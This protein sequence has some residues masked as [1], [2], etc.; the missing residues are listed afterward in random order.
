MNLAKRQEGWSK[1]Q[2][3]IIIILVILLII[4]A[5]PGYL[6]GGNWTWSDLPQVENINQVKSVLKT[7][8]ELPG[9]QIIKQQ[10]VRIGGHKWSAQMMKQENSKPVML[11]LLPQ[12]YYLNKP[13]VEWMDING[14][15]RWK[16]DS[17]RQLNFT[18]TKNSRSVSVKARFF[19]AWNQQ[20][21]AVVQW[22]AFN[23]GGHFSPANWFW[24]DQL[25][26]LSDRRVPWVA[27]CLKI[28]IEPL[29][30]LKDA[31]SVA[32][33]LA[34]TVQTQLNNTVFSNYR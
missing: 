27:V 9:W 16:T 6:R 15:E 20:T 12:S 4:G 34:K 29:G 11:L 28:P 2:I 19:R 31:Q 13:E 22:Y 23:N 33:S 18:I 21:F 8:L 32:E 17:N 30:E 5:F 26:Q 14:I 1:A 7:G 25:A 10:E 3:I 24:Q